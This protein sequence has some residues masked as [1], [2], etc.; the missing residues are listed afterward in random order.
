MTTYHINIEDD[1]LKVGFGEPANND[2][3]VQ[4][5]AARLDELIETGQLSGGALLKINGPASVPVSYVIAHKVSHL[6]GAIA[7]FDPKMGEKGTNKYIIAIAHNPTYNIGDMLDSPDQL[8]GNQSQHPR[9]KVVLCGPPQSGKSCL[10]EGLKQA[11]CRIEGA[12]YPYVITACPDGEGAWFSEAARRD[13]DLARKLK[14]DYKANFTPEFAR[15]RA[16]WVRDAKNSL[17]IIDV[18]GKISEENR[19]IMSQATHAVILAGNMNK[20][21]AWKD[22]CES[23][24]LPVI[25]II[26]SDYKG[27]ADCIQTESP[28]LTGSVHYL[29]RGEDIST[30]PMVQALATLLVNRVNSG[31]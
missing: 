18:G 20:V 17:N 23:L 11:I 14:E 31:E 7:V 27:V 29:E 22:F 24:N 13:A 10:R 1:V 8:Q 4:D 26:H 25:A 30:R 19:Q 15:I 2:R 5:A 28:L 6:Y 12:P 9:M 16:G 3:I 21:P